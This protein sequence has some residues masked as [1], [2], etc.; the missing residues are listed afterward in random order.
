MAVAGAF[1]GPF[2]ALLAAA[3]ALMAGGGLA[4]IIVAWRLIEPR[5]AVQSS[6]AEAASTWRREA[7]IS[8]VGKERF[9]YALAIATGVVAMLWQRGSISSLLALVGVP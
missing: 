2:H 9:P 4:V 7:T 6:S 3:M 5:S 8:N 1:L